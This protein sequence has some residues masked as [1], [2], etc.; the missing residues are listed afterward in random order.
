MSE[1]TR[2]AWLARLSVNVLYSTITRFV[3][4]DDAE[5]RM[6]GLLGADLV[7]MPYRRSRGDFFLQLSA[8]ED[9]SE[10]G[11]YLEGN[12]AWP[13]ASYYGSAGGELRLYFV[14][15]D[16]LMHYLLGTS[17]YADDPYTEEQT[18]TCPFNDGR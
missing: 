12:K 11:I 4:G 8:R 16:A 13:I 1:Y 10:F 6:M 14:A 18:G 5:A 2:L 3:L 15:E 7:E 17:P 9:G